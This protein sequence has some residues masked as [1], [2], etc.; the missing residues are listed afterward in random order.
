LEPW[1]ATSFATKVDFTTG[2]APHSVSLQDLDEDGKPEMVIANHNSNTLSVLKNNSAPGI[3][4]ASSFAAKI[5]F[6]TG[7]NPQSVGI[8][9]LDGDGKPDL[10]VTN[11]NA[12]TNTLSVLRNTTSTGTINA[13]SF[14]TKVDFTTGVLSEESLQSE[15]LT[16]M[17]NLI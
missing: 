2:A 12:G 9:D 3:I 15:I 11:G 5:D 4:N 1:D 16:M 8:A 14:A 13:S 17:A 7:T 6:G 10:V